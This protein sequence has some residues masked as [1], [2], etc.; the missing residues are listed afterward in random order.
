MSIQPSDYLSLSIDERWQLI[1]DIQVSISSESKV[2]NLS[3][4]QQQELRRRVAHLD[5]HPDDVLTYEELKAGLRIQ[6]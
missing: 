4:E 3:V 1:E 2:T 6:S 5:A